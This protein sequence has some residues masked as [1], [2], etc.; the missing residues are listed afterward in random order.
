[1]AVTYFVYKPHMQNG[2]KKET[3]KTDKWREKKTK[4]NWKEKKIESI[5]NTPHSLVQGQ[6]LNFY[7]VFQ[8][9]HDGFCL[10][11]IIGSRNSTA[12]TFLC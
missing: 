8:L 1:M 11:K 2:K 7:L 4:G 12:I 9:A 10:L 6:M 5:K 3:R